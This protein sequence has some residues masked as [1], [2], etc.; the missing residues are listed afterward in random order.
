MALIGD[1]AGG[2]LALGLLG[3]LRNAGEALPGCGVLLSAATDL[4][5]I[6]RSVI[7]NERSDAMF[8]VPTLML[9]RHWYL[10]EHNPTDPR[11]SPYWGDFTGFPPLLFQVSASEML[12]DNSRYAEAKAARQGVSTRLSVW[13]GMPHDFPLFAFLPEARA[14]L[15]EQVAFI[16]ARL[17]PE[18]PVSGH[19]PGEKAPG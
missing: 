15:A 2:A 5:T 1:S 4:T 11:I 16:R 6:G 17:G 19:E 8:G 7:D 3:E 9:F 14:A 10:G 13:P 12:L 18:A